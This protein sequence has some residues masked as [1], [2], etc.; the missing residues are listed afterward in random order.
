MTHQRATWELGLSPLTRGNRVLGLPHHRQH[1]P[2]P[3]HAG[4][5]PPSCAARWRSRAYPRSRGATIKL[6]LLLDNAQGLSPLTRGNH[7]RRGAGVGAQGPIPAHA[8]QPWLRVGSSRTRRAYP[9]S[10]GATASRRACSVSVWGL[11]PLTRGNLERAV[12]E[13]AGF[14]PIPAHAGQPEVGAAIDVGEGAY[15]R[16]RGATGPRFVTPSGMRGLSPLTR[17]NLLV[18]P[19][20]RVCRGPIPAHAGQPAGRLEHQRPARAYPRSRG[21]TTLVE[22]WGDANKGLSPLTRGNLDGGDRGAR[23]LG[24]I[25]AHA[26]QP[27]CLVSSGCWAGAYPRSRGATDPAVQDGR[28][29]SG[30]SPLTRGNPAAAAAD[31]GQDGPIP[32]HAGQP[33][34]RGLPAWRQGAYPRSRGA[35]PARRSAERMMLGLSPLTRG[36]HAVR[37]RRRHPSG[38]IPAHAGQP[39]AHSCARCPPRAYPRSRGATP[40]GTINYATGQGLSPLTRGNRSRDHGRRALGGPIPAHAG[41]PPHRLHHHLAGRA[42]PRSRG[43]TQDGAHLFVDQ[44]GLS[45]LTRGNRAAVEFLRVDRGPIPAHAGQPAA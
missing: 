28:P 5:P 13:L 30:L 11:S 8:G 38:P 44:Q 34:G 3:A 7:A 24:P 36:N 21:A 33:F 12:L 14:G 4:Q 16:S 10:R 31:A 9:R 23:A 40:V 19:V 20:R 29:E 15:P 18:L 17:G 25:P 26:G 41:Q 39:S 6:K 37:A 35:T 1:G 43:A 2:I 27:R 22:G 32:A 45:P 42:Y